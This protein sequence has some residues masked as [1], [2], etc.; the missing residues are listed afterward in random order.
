MLVN[1]R[2]LQTASMYNTNERCLHGKP[3]YVGETDH[4]LVTTSN[5]SRQV[6]KIFQTLSLL[7]RSNNISCM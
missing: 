4:K 1:G 5:H 7:K 3:T 2:I 6:I